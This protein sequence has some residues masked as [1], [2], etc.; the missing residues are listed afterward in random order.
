[1][2]TQA[3]SEDYRK[4]PSKQTVVTIGRRLLEIVVYTK[5]CRIGG[6]LSVDDIAKRRKL[7]TGR[8]L[9][10]RRP[11]HTRHHRVG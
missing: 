11:A 7:A 5:H 10:S 8:C 2:N 3:S 9:N 1:M 6:K 4:L